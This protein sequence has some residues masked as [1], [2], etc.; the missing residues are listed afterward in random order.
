MGDEEGF[1]IRIQSQQ[2]WQLATRGK[3]RC[4]ARTEHCKP[5]FLTS[6][7][8]FPGVAASMRL[9]SMHCLSCDFAQDSKS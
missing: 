2:T 1:Q 7:W 5:V 6:F 9:H 4:P 8:L 3:G